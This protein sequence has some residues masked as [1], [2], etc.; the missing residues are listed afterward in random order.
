MTAEK[1]QGLLFA[2][3]LDGKGSGRE[4]GWPEIKAWS[5]TDGILWIHLDGTS[6]DTESWLRNESN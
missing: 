1:D 3:I 5:T 2:Y 6:P 4:V